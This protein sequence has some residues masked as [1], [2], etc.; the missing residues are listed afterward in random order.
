[1]QPSRVRKDVE[2][3]ERIVTWLEGWQVR[4]QRGLEITGIRR[5]ALSAAATFR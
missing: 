1:M 2:Q 3:I 4:R 5:N